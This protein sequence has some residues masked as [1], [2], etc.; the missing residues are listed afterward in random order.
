MNEITGK[1]EGILFA[2]AKPMSPKRLAKT[3]DVSEEI[4]HEAI[5]ELKQIRN[6]EISGIH[7]M[8]HEGGITLVTNPGQADLLATFVKE[9]LAG[10]LT[11]PS[12][13]TLT[14]IAYRG[15]MTKPEIEQIRGVNCSL[16]LRNL[17]MRDMVLEKMDNE[18][19]QM[20]Y[21]VSQNF[22]QH[23]GMKSVSELPSYQSFANNEEIDRLITEMQET[24]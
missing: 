23:L 4:V 11:R 16:I 18:K 24:T 6:N 19:L 13:E 9:D 1:I 2:V 14:I 17:L 12:L 8:D 15:P 3:L 7:V 22:L 5:E 20:V 10:E 21:L